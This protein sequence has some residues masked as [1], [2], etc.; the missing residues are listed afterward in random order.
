MKYAVVTMV[1]RVRI[2]GQYIDKVTYYTKYVRNEE[3][4]KNLMK[5]ENVVIVKDLTTNETILNKLK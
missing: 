4:L 2:N 1:N 5:R 3:T